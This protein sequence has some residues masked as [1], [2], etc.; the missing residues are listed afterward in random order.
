MA[1]EYFAAGQKR[2][3][4][5]CTRS[6]LTSAQCLFMA[7]TYFMFVLRPV[8]GWRLL[9]AASIACRTY[10]SKRIA[11]ESF[12]L[13]HDGSRSMEQRLYWSCFKAER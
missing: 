8:A 4:P 12:G 11:R 5:L 10:I 3:G 7:G 9:N 1:Q 6:S 13:R 2:L